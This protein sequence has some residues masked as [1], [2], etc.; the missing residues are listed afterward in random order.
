L[1]EQGT[2]EAHGLTQDGAV[3]L[4]GLGQYRNYRIA[5]EMHEQEG[6]E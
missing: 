4:G 3:S 6:D 5:R 2:I 1:Y